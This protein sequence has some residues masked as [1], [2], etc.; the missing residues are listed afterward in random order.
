[1]KYFVK[2]N[3]SRFVSYE[4]MTQETIMAMLAEQNLAYEFVSEADYEQVIAAYQA[5]QESTASQTRVIT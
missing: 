4:G 5:A 1:M 2:I 3:G